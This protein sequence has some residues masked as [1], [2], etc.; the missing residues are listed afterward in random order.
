MSLRATAPLLDVKPYLMALLED[1]NADSV[2]RVTGTLWRLHCRFHPYSAAHNNY[3][4]ETAG[5]EIV[6]GEWEIVGLD[7]SQTGETFGILHGT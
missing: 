1:G 4:P 2:I 5:I 7:N 6:V 3:G